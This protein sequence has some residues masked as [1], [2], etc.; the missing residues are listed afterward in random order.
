MLI[1]WHNTSKFK[2]TLPALKFINTFYLYGYEAVDILY[3]LNVCV[4]RL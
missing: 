3:H 1:N 4:M 2:I